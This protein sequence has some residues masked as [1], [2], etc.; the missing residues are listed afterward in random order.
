MVS[1]PRTNCR[2]H[3]AWFARSRSI[4]CERRFTDC[5]RSG[6]E[7][8]NFAMSRQG[9]SASMTTPPGAVLI[10]LHSWD[11]RFSGSAWRRPSSRTRLRTPIV[12]RRRLTG[13]ATFRSATLTTRPSSTVIRTETAVSADAQPTTLIPRDAARR[14]C[15]GPMA[16]KFVAL[17]AAGT[18]LAG[19]L[20][21]ASPASAAPWTMQISS[22]WICR[23]HRTPSSP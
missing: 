18:Q 10:A 8:G 16:H 17:D 21:A 9:L 22:T 5:R 1:P 4:C 12:R 7:C 2:G 23:A 11:S 14:W 15:D 13:P 19:G 3:S 6:L 20:A